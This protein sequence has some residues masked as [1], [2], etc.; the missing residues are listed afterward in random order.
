MHSRYFSCV[1][2]GALALTITTA[3]AAAPQIIDPEK[4]TEHVRVLASDEFEG[5]APAS[6]GEKK[7]IE[8]LIAQLKAAGLQPG[9][10]QQESGRAWTQ[11]VPL[12]RTE[13]KGPMNIS[14]RTDSETLQWK[15]SE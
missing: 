10:D 12:L 4:I 14:V 3:M 15:Q 7:T 9:G 11:D 13:I 5:R 1:V 8:Y 6:A 2:A